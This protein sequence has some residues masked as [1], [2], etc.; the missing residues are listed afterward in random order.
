MSVVVGLAL[1]AFGGL[2]AVAGVRRLGTA[3][4]L[5][6]T[7]AVSLRD[8]PRT[9]GTVEFEGQARSL[10]DED[11]L[12]APLSGEDALCC[13]VWMETGDRHR[14]DVD[15]AEV[16]ESKEPETYRNTEQS[17][18]LAESDEF[19]QPFIVADGGARVAVDPANADLDIT[20]HMGETVLTVDSGESLPDDVHERLARL[21]R[22]GVEFDTAFETWDR[23][24]DRVKYREARLEP[25][26]PV[27][28]AGGAVEN[29][30]DEWGA[31]VDATVGGSGTGDRFLIS[32]GTESS[33]VRKHFIQF[34]TGVV[35]G[36]IL[37]VLGISA[38]GV[39]I[40]V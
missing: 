25:G 33:V 23:E 13:A 22:E 9:D 14:T 18:L 12:E 19:E 34:I 16:L 7:D 28:V 1:C 24:D 32:Q 36:T 30:P 40:P 17:W 6:R 37:L 31:E 2:L 26:D 5:S 3:V 11:P 39:A 29:V 27:H 35:V 8:V 20:G 38:L 10:A 4:S 15:G 21:D